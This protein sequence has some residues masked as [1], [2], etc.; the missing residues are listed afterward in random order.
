MHLFRVFFD[1]MKQSALSLSAALGFYRD[2]SQYHVIINISPFLF[3]VLLVPEQRSLIEDRMNAEEQRD[4]THHEITWVPLFLV[5]LRLGLRRY[6]RVYNFQLVIITGWLRN[7]QK[8][9]IFISL[10]REISS[11]NISFV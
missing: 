7:K 8:K 10:P 5:L 4:Y 9:I 3:T 11:S 1:M 2:I 6:P